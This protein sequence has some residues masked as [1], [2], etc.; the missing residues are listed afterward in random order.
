MRAK[1]VSVE[2]TQI[3][4]AFNIPTNDALVQWS[5]E[6][7]CK[8][9][10]NVLNSAT[11]EVWPL[12]TVVTNNG[13]ISPD[14][15]QEGTVRLQQQKWD[16]PVPI[17]M[18]SDN[19][20]E[21]SYH[22][23]DVQDHL[24][25]SNTLRKI[26]PSNSTLD[27]KSIHHMK[28]YSSIAHILKQGQRLLPL[29]Y[30]K[31]KD[32]HEKSFSSLKNFWDHMRKI[33][34]ESIKPVQ[35][36]G[37]CAR[38]EVSVRPGSHGNGDILRCQGHLID[39]LA[40]VQIAI[41]DLFCGMHK[42]RFKTIPFEFVYPKTLSL[43]D[44]VE[45]QTR[46]RASRSFCDLFPGE[47]YEEWL[48]AFVTLIMITAG[49]TGELK[50]KCVAKWLKDSKRHD[51]TN[52]AP[53]ILANFLS[54]DNSDEAMIEA[55][56]RTPQ[57]IPQNLL[58]IL[59]KLLCDLKFTKTSCDCICEFLKLELSHKPSSHSRIWYLKLSLKDKLRF[60][61]N[62]HTT[63]IVNLFTILHKRCD[64]AT[65]K[66]HQQPSGITIPT[67]PEA[68][69]E[70]DSTIVDIADDSWDD[71]HL[72]QYTQ[73]HHEDPLVFMPT[74]I[75]DS[76]F[77]LNQFQEHT[78]GK[79]YRKW[80]YSPPEDPT[81]LLIMRLLDLARFTDVQAPVFITRLYHYI[82]I[83]HN[84]EIRL[85][86]QRENLKRLDC[87]NIHHLTFC[88][89]SRCLRDN[90]ADVNSLHTI[91]IGLG[92][93]ILGSGTHSGELLL[94]SLSYHYYFPCSSRQSCSHPLDESLFEED[95]LRPLDELLEKTLQTEFVFELPCFTNT[96][97]HFFR[98]SD[99]LHL[100]I[101][102]K[103]FVSSPTTCD[104][105]AGTTT[106]EAA[107]DIHIVIDLC[108][109]W[110]GIWGEDSRRNMSEFLSARECLC[111][112]FLLEDARN[113]PNFLNSQTLSQLESQKYFVLMDGWNV[114][115]EHYWNMCPDVIMPSLSLLHQCNIFFIDKDEQQSQLH[116]FDK[117]SCKVI[118][119]LFPNTTTSPSVKWHVFWKQDTSYKYTSFI[120][121]QVT[122]PPN[123]NLFQGI[124][125]HVNAFKKHPQGEP[126][127][128]K[129]LA[130]SILKL[131]M[132]KHVN[133]E[134]FRTPHKENDILDIHP[135]VGE[136]F[137][138]NKSLEDLFSANIVQKL[139]QGNIFSLEGLWSQV[140]KENTILLH[141]ILCP[142]LCLKYT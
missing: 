82:K 65:D 107:Y 18:F 123:S 74:T 45:S 11:A 55:I 35:R 30:V 12:H 34:G 83:C 113:N 103:E 115:D 137:A 24:Q 78:F 102:K 132:S 101:A 109:N 116:I 67:I 77:A 99:N 141:T 70:V 81:M 72:A 71:R 88:N 87:D 112:D 43:I 5:Y 39:I 59:N 106:T 121:R 128:A 85:P 129:S 38:I 126:L 4:V 96:M 62:I 119:Y 57:E 135:Y 46:F 66:R 8:K 133:H 10:A 14:R 1:G 105:T 64:A 44:Q 117:K 130:D 63:V 136:L 131:L 80:R 79:S 23:N 100:Y 58:K 139:N 84:T 41:H 47:K 28:F 124:P 32:F 127:T 48:K 97:T 61:Q 90:C 9:S 51:P 33:S 114:P 134:H 94:A 19:N 25:W 93:R 86:M 49:L 111:D 2:L 37:I 91:C 3:D 15:N 108:L 120:Q 20:E 29:T 50:L 36:H 89:A 69:P 42:V 138:S 122:I 31:M 104:V 68:I 21:D 22:S 56:T 7:D 125:K 118:T 92:V 6:R 16:S 27:A 60:A 98:Q 13:L 76:A 54:L 142:I 140:K 75:R 17:C 53:K 52:Q 26:Y 95:V 73:Y 40:H 110:H